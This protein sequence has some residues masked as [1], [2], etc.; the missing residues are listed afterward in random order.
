MTRKERSGHRPDLSKTC[1]A[2]GEKAQPVSL[3]LSFL[4]PFLRKAKHSMVASAG[5]PFSK[6]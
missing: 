6:A 1:W 4:T 3:P 2:F 5:W